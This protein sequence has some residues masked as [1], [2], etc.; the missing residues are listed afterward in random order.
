MFS[1]TISEIPKT[2]LTISC[3]E[4]F[5][6]AGYLS[7]LFL[8][9]VRHLFNR[10]GVAGAVLQTASSLIKV[11]HCLWKYIPNIVNPRP[12]EPGRL[13]CERMF[14]PHYVS[15]VTCY[16]SRVT[17]HLSPVIFFHFFL[18]IFFHKKNPC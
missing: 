13:N 18:K 6:W 1:W 8:G 3:T 4:D 16:V 9:I 11:G 10:P 15:C 12:E 17:C 14:I 2:C 7:D 5:R